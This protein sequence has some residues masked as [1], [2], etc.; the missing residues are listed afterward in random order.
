MTIP[1]VRDFNLSR[2]AALKHLNKV[3]PQLGTF[4]RD[5]RNF[6]PGPFN[7]D[8]VTELSPSL[9]HRV[10][11]EQ[12]VIREV[13]LSHSFDIAA[14][15]ITEVFWRTYWKGWLEM[16][17]TVWQDYQKKRDQDITNWEN[18]DKLIKALDGDTGIECFDSWVKELCETNYLHNHAR[19]WFA[20]IW[21]FTLQLPWT[22]GADFFLKHLLDGDPASN[23]LS[24]RWVA[25]LQT[26]G[27]AYL[28]LADNIRKF[29]LGRFNPKNDII[30]NAKPLEW[31]E[32]PRPQ[33]I[34]A[35]DGFKS[36]VP[37]L[38]IVTEDDLSLRN[39]PL[40]HSNIVCI[41][42]LNSTKKRS[43]M[44]VS[45]SVIEFSNEAIYNAVTDYANANAIPITCLS[46]VPIGEIPKI[47]HDLGVRQIVSL[48]SPVGPSQEIIGKV[49]AMAEKQALPIIT[50]MRDWDAICWPYATKG[51]FKFK[52]SIPTFIKQ[53]NLT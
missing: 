24:W 23:T 32:P 7:H 18:N 30:E 27:K 52:E 39:A 22:L 53:F 43:I 35:N 19:M 17:P 20:S 36:N 49:N 9:R 8:A 26:R 50:V 45:N 10:V 15:F 48:Y 31:Q 47:T 4:Y 11:L 5:N 37:T 34:L 41:I 29:T 38:L 44:G 42:S 25:G 2:S 40:P 46:N 21:I 51:F 1:S 16:R 14:K 33:K 6:D 3:I 12:E 28:A 13:L